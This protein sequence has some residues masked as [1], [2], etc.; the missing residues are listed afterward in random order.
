MPYKTT[1]FGEIEV[2]QDKVLHFKEGVIGFE[3]LH[4]FVILKHRPSSCFFWLQ[5]LE[6]PDLAFS[7]LFP[8]EF[9]PSYFPRITREDLTV[10]GAEEQ[11]SLEIYSM[12]V[13]PRDP[14]LMTINLLSPVVIN[15]LNQRGKQIVLLDSGYSVHQTLTGESQ[16]ASPRKATGTDQGG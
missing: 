8:F 9:F 4:D 11:K 16:E 12:V 2:P 13:V 5:S 6:K 15:P 3:N 7:M 10:L 1:R 14:A